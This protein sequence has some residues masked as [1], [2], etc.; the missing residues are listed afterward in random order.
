MVDRT[1]DFYIAM[2]VTSAEDYVK[3]FLKNDIG[4]MKIERLFMESRTGHFDPEFTSRLPKMLEQETKIAINIIDKFM[5]GAES[6]IPVNQRKCVPWIMREVIRFKYPN[7]AKLQSKTT[8]G[9]VY[10]KVVKCDAV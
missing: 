3:A 9:H 4:G 2:Y 5:R 7:R 1:D 6:A 8:A 10:Y